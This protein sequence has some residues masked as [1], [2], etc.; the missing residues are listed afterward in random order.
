MTKG[1]E[2][3]AIIVFFILGVTFFVLTMTIDSIKPKPVFYDVGIF[4][5]L[6]GIIM[7]IINSV[8]YLRRRKQR[9]N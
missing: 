4:L 1:R 7:G 8:V 3:Y 5:I 2:I 6:M 9:E